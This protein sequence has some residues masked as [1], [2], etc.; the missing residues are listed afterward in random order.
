MSDEHS[1]E[2][3]N[4]ERLAAS[5]AMRRSIVV[6]LMELE[7]GVRVSLIEDAVAEVVDNPRDGSWIIV[8]YLESP[9]DPSKVGSEEPVFAA[10]V[11][12]TAE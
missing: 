10:D 12:G 1:A 3:Q 11:L 7:V 8:R 2:Q 9:S 6:N 4:S 5:D